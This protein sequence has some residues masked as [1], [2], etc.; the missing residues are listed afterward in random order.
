MARGYHI[1]IKSTQIIIDDIL[2][3]YIG[4]KYNSWN[5]TGFISTGGSGINDPGNSYLSNF[6]GI[7]SNVFICP[8]FFLS[9][10]KV[11]LMAVI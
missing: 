4:Y 7:F 10:L 5:I 11:I 3:T 8:V 9:L 1:V 6:P 2:L